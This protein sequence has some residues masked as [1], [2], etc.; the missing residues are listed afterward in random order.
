[1]KTHLLGL[2][3]ATGL[4]VLAA[5]SAKPIDDSETGGDAVTAGTLDDGFATSVLAGGCTVVVEGSS[6]TTAG[7]DGK[8]PTELSKVLDL[9]DASSN[10]PSV[11]VVS[12]K[13]DLPNDPDTSFRFVISSK[14]GTNPFF[15]AALGSGNLGE[16]GL[17]AMGFSPTLQAFAYYKVEGGRWVR[18]GDATQVKSTTTG[19]DRPFECIGCHST[20][21]PLMKELHDSWGNWTS[22]WDTVKGPTEQNELFKRLFGK[23]QRADNLELAII[24]GIKLHSKGRVDRAKADGQLKGVLSQLMCE[25]GEPS[26][27]GAHSKSST[28]LDKVSTFS[29]MLP[30][31][32]MLNQL[33][34]PPRTGGTG[35]ELGF[36]QSLKLNVPSARSLGVDATAYAKAVADNGQTIGGKAGDTIFPMSSPEKSH[37]DLD[38][39]QELLR[40]NLI[41]NEIVADILM[42]DYTVSAF[43]KIRCDLAQTM[44]ETWD[45]PATL[46]K[47]WAQAL[48]S[49]SLRG[50]KGLAARL[51]Q[52][53]I[54]AHE[55][56]LEAY[57]AACAKRGAPALTPDVLKIMSQRRVE[58]E[59]RYS[60]VIES[61]WLIPQDNLGSRAGAIRLKAADC[62]VEDAKNTFDGEDSATKD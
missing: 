37:A 21:A 29:S 6:T 50:A 38:A 52:D 44:P 60:S 27:V 2:L 5:C 31:A 39:V 61:D 11:F 4:A 45:S 40:Q 19:K 57:A 17:E 8:C 46:K 35:V 41:D 7:S 34:V 22:T 15:V 42:T 33:L 56:K 62:T 49:S 55:A 32:I 13:G 30:G 53:D 59:A 12:E 23:V 3:S 25:I 24:E 51:G 36:E 20:G 26:L 54:K 43:S 18:K 48:S 9:M 10:K 58:F 1:M 28:R 47:T 14:D 16:G